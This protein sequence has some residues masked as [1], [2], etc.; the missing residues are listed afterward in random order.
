[1]GACDTTA[2]SAPSISDPFAGS[3]EAATTL[4]EVGGPEMNHDITVGM[5]WAEDVAYGLGKTYGRYG[6]QYAWFSE[7]LRRQAQ[8]ERERHDRPD[9]RP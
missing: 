7:F 2:Y 8:R 1:L 3:T 4:K 5:K 9:P 6:P